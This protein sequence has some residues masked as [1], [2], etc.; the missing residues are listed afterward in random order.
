[1]Y[2]CICVHVHRYTK[3]IQGSQFYGPSNCHDCY[4]VA[5]PWLKDEPKE[6]KITELSKGG[7]MLYHILDC[8]IQG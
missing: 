3:K 4:R 7:K 5:R 2:V 6:K 8:I 1:M